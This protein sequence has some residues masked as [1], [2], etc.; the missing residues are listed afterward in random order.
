MKDNNIQIAIDGP[1][2]S[3]KSTIAKLLAD[4]YHLVY[5]DTGAMYRTLTYLALK[6]KINIDDEQAL[7]AL[8]KEVNITFKRA[9][10]GQDV[11]ANGE[12]IT[13]KIREHEVTNNVSVV[14]SFPNV[15]KELVRRQQALAKESGVVMDGRDIGTVVLPNADVKIFLIASV[16]ERAN[17]RYLENQKKGIETNFERLKEE[18]IARDDY[19]SNRKESPLKQAEDAICVD[20]TGLSITEV[21]NKCVELI[22][23]K[24]K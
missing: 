8:L 22:N 7:T 9:K 20:T 13:K 2:S 24:I 4:K 16:E 15:R 1:A 12:K 14:S 3:G 23:K 10:D 6:N 19:D 11:F 5:V 17:R 21:V 18:I